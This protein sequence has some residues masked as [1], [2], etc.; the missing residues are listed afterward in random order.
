MK[1]SKRI[2]RVR[3]RLARADYDRKS[4]N[5]SATRKRARARAFDREGVSARTVGTG[6][7]LLA[8]LESRLSSASAPNT[9]ASTRTGTAVPVDGWTVN[10]TLCDD[11]RDSGLRDGDITWECSDRADEFRRFSIMR[12]AAFTVSS[13]FVRARAGV[14]LWSALSARPQK[15]FST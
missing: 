6:L 15:Y 7:K 9:R 10:V 14:D 12:P 4:G 5:A 2:R 11:T 8:S 1:F 3:V 13:L